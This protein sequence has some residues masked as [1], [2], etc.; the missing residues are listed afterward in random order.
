MLLA[1]V[2]WRLA[3][4]LAVL[5]CAGCGRATQFGA[6]NHRLLASLQTAVSAKR[7][8]W[9]DATAKVIAERHASGQLNDEQATELESIVAKARGGD[10]P[11][12]EV[13][14][15]RLLKAQR[16]S[17]AERGDSNLSPAASGK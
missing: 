11:G 15:V 5:S 10:W 17:A 3:L 16:T 1:R 6:D 12:A 13:D 4:A 2:S 14:V 9:L 7:S 8:D